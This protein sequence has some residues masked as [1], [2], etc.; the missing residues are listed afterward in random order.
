MK[1]IVLIS[2][3]FSLSLLVKS[4]DQQ[5]PPPKFYLGFQYSAGFFYP[6][7]VND[8]IDNY[9]KVHNIIIQA[10]SSAIFMNHCFDFTGLYMVNSVIGIQGGADIAFAPKF[11]SVSNGESK[12]FNFWRFSPWGG[13][14]LYAGSFCI[15][16]KGMYNMM[17][18]EGYKVSKL[19]WNV[20]ASYGVN[21]STLRFSPFIAFDYAKG[22]ATNNFE[23]NFT[24]V[25]FGF[26]LLIGVK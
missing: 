16:G 18:F 1:K 5:S 19:G 23:L 22:D 6:S 4:Q 14:N 12:F 3:L 13:A 9:L 15:S 10:G 7:D 24:N 26:E 17:S 11:L 2:V 8:Y 20:T 21:I 25:R